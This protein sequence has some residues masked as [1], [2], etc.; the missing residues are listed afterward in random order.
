MK[1]CDRQELADSIATV[2]DDYHDKPSWYVAQKI[3]QLCFLDEL[4]KIKGH[5]ERL[6]YTDTSN[7]N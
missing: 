6:F 3:I 4:E 1:F 2:L 5:Y 7:K